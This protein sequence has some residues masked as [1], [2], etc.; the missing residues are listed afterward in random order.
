MTLTYDMARACVAAAMAKAFEIGIA[1]TI[2]VLDGGGHVKSLARMDGAW[3]GSIDVAMKKAKTSVLF[4]METQAI[5]EFS[6]PEAQAHGLESTNGGLV[7]FA[8]GIPLKSSGGTLLGALGVSGGQ[9][10]Q[11]LAIAEAGVAACNF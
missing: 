5:W 9:V 6:K 8:G 10:A 11:D 4:E 1:A 7:T 3:L 2:V